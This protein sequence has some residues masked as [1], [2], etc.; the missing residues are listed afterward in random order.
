MPFNCECERNLEPQES[1]WHAMDVT[2]LRD[3][4]V[5]RESSLRPA[6]ASFIVSRLKAKS[7]KEVYTSSQYF[8]TATLFFLGIRC[9]PDISQDSHWSKN[10]HVNIETEFM[11]SL[12]DF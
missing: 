6:W 1:V 9:F 7:P 2:I 5:W 8:T 12:I 10:T 3:I 11:Y 4:L